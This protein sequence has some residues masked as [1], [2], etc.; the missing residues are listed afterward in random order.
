MT[1]ELKRYRKA[2]KK[3][4][5]DLIKY[6]ANEENPYCSHQIPAVLMKMLK[7]RLEY[8]EANDNVFMDEDTRTEVV[9]TLRKAVNLGILATANADLYSIAL[10]T[11]GFEKLRTNAL[12][13]FQQMYD[14]QIKA[15]RAWFNYIARHFMEWWD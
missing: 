8:F 10:E 11:E 14:K 4:M 7:R 2:Q 13:E 12:D 3:Y 1:P 6:I 9:K 15:Y 5:K